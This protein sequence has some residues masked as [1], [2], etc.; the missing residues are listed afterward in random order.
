MA[1]RTNNNSKG[2]ATSKVTQV[3][4]R[5]VF[6]TVITPS[7][8]KGG[9]PCNC[10][11]IDPASKETSTWVG[12]LGA[13]GKGAT[14]CFAQGHDAS[15]KSTLGVAFKAGVTLRVFSADGSRMAETDNPLDFLLRFAP[16][17]EQYTT[18]AAHEK[19]IAA[20]EKALAERIEA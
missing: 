20:R 10:V 12:R 5:D 16:L 11:T 8:E 17:H 6:P 14:N 13:C 4:P 7:K 18:A 1:T 2:A 3:A 19:R 9:N 15:L